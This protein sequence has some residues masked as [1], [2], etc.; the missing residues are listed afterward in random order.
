MLWDTGGRQGKPSHSCTAGGFSHHLQKNP[1]TTLK[2]VNLTRNTSRL[3]MGTFRRAGQHMA[4]LPA[5]PGMSEGFYRLSSHLREFWLVGKE[6]KLGGKSRGGQ[7][8]EQPRGLPGSRPGRGHARQARR[9]R[10]GSPARPS[11]DAA[12][13]KSPGERDVPV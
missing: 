9:H 2:R 1:E 6:E 12:A 7:A 13:V 8:G 10:H 4:T 5:H 3:E 11:V